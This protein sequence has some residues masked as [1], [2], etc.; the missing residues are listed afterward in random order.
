[1]LLQDT[2]V[3]PER[4]IGFA[5]QIHGISD[6]MVAGTL[7]PTLFATEFRHSE[8]A[9]RPF[10]TEE[11]TFNARFAPGSMLNV[12]PELVDAFSNHRRAGRPACRR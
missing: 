10:S 8:L 11:Q 4:P 3:N 2:L 6:E 1:M 7:Q 12:M 9:T 5:T